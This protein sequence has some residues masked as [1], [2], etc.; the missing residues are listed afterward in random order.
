MPMVM[1]VQDLAPEQQE[2]VWVLV[3]VTLL[4][5]HW[6]LVEEFSIQLHCS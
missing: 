1:K 3:L 5:A 2:E 6:I 4:L